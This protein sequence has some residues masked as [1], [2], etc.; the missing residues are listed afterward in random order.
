M[1]RSTV[2][3]G[4]ASAAAV[5]ADAEAPEGA[6]SQSGSDSDV[7][8]DAHDFTADGVLPEALTSLHTVKSASERAAQLA[9]DVHLVNT[10]IGMANINSRYPKNLH[11]LHQ[12]D[13]TGEISTTA[14]MLLVPTHDTPGVNTASLAESQAFRSGSFTDVPVS[15]DWVKVSKKF[16]TQSKRIMSEKGML[17]DKSISGAAVGAAGPSGP[18]RY[19]VNKIARG[20]LGSGLHEVWIKDLI[21]HCG[22]KALVICDFAHGVGE[23]MKAAVNCKVAEAAT[24]TG[25]RVCAWGQDP[26]KVFFPKSGQPLAA[27][28]CPN[29]M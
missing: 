22:T 11:F 1:K 7:D 10:V 27:P 23:V 4:G 13:G 2:V 29:C 18:V 17:D 21:K 14:A 24:T 28:R 20:Q 5:G 19:A 26:R 15:T 25:V 12:A 9:Q 6:G 8:A 16:A 3:N